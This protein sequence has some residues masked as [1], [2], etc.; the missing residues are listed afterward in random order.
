MVFP[1]V[2]SINMYPYPPVK[3]WSQ[4]TIN[5]DYFP[6]MNSSLTLLVPQPTQVNQTADSVDKQKIHESFWNGNIYFEESDCE[7]MPDLNLAGSAVQSYM[8]ELTKGTE[9]EKSASGSEEDSDSEDEREISHGSDAN[10]F[11]EDE[12]T[13][14][15]SHW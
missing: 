15:V 7:E 13:E 12:E 8:F 2:K 9:G 3:V 14:D 4:R 1:F 10:E 5:N 6:W 11:D